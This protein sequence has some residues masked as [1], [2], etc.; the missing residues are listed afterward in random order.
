MVGVRVEAGPALVGRAATLGR[1]GARAARPR[2]R[3]AHPQPCT[4]RRRE[5]LAAAL[6]LVIVLRVAAQ[7]ARVVDHAAKAELAEA[8][9]AARLVQGR[10]GED[11]Q[12]GRDAVGGR[13]AVDGV[14]RG[15]VGVST[16]REH[17]RL[18][19]RLRRLRGRVVGA[20]LRAILVESH[21]R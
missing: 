19:G 1:A 8:V 4:A 9:D 12:T 17:R 6:R 16:L 3:A 13:G 14:G 15:A 5:R 21:A 2:R 18:I 10:A 11:A 7:T 20:R